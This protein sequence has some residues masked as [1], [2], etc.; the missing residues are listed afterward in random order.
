[1][2]LLQAALARDLHD[3]DRVLGRERDQQNQADLH[4]EIGIDLQRDEDRGRTDQRERNRQHD[5]ERRVPALI[6]PGEHQ[7]DQQQPHA[8]HK[9]HLIADDLL[10]K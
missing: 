6:L 7:I 2:A 4:V 1:M 5:R 10:L 8:E 3:Q 9:V